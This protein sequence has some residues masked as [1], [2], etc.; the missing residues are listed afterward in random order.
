[1]AGLGETIAAL[2]ASR[3]PPQGKHDHAGGQWLQEISAFG[4]NPGR[5][6]MLLHVPEALAARPALVVVLHGCGQTAAAYADGAGW[7]TLADR[8]GFVVLC[9]EQTRANNANLCFNWF[10][11]GD[12]TRGAGEAASIYGMIERAIADHDLDRSRVFITGL[13]AGGA[14]AN[15]MLAAYPE[16]FAAGAVV[17]GLPYGAASSMVEAFSAMQGGGRRSAQAWGDAVRDGGHTGRWPRVAIWQGDDDGTVAPSV[18][19]DLAAQWT[20]VHGVQGPAVQR[21]ARKGHRHATWRSPSGEAV[22]ELHRIARMGHGAPLACAGP[23]G[24]GTAGPYLLEVGISSSLEMA[25]S[26]GLAAAQDERRARGQAASSQ[27]RATESQTSRSP[28]ADQRRAMGSRMDRRAETVIS[29][30][31]RSA[32]LIK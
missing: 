24:C 17:A 16:T 27:R 19:E 26:W 32:G 28:G 23:D 31:L 6:R 1:M 20:N 9:P 21:L 10:Q 11:A 18:A 12:V 13:S 8:C 14:M 3:R 2:V 29:N 7:R 4:D 25:Q 5:L 22:V 30:A 15:A